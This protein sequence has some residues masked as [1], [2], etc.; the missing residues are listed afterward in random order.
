[1]LERLYIKDI[2][3][4][5]EVDL[6][7]REG[8]TVVTGETGAGKSMLMDAFGLAL[9]ERADVSLVR[10]GADEA[11]VEA[12]FDLSG[13]IY[14]SIK[15]IAEDLGIPL[16]EDF[17]VLRRFVSAS[18]KSKAFANGMRVTLGQLQ[19]LS[20]YLADIHGQRDNQFLL[21]PQHHAQ[22]LDNFAG[23]KEQRKCVAKCWRQWR[24]I[25]N[26]LQELMARHES[27]DRE[28]GLLTAYL[29][30]LEEVNYNTG[31]EISLVK[32]RAR[33]M[34]GEQTIEALQMLDLAFDDEWISQ[35]QRAERALAGVAD[36]AGENVEA[37]AKRVDSLV[38][39]ITDIISD[40]RGLAENTRPDPEM[41]QQVDNRLS[42]L[43][44]IARKHSVDVSEIIVVQQ[45]LSKQLEDL[46]LLQDGM[47]DLV[48]HEKE[49]RIEYEK[50]AYKLSELRKK[51]S[52][53]M[54]K[55]V[56]NALA[57]LKMESTSFYVDFQQLEENQWN[58]G[59]CD[60][61][62]FMLAVNAGV[63]LQPLEKV[64]SGGEVSR[65]MLAL[66]QVFFAA[67]PSRTLVFDEIDTG[68]GGAVADAVGDALGELGKR[69]Q[70]LVVTHQ[71]QVA[72]KGGQHL[73]IEKLTDGKITR[74][75]AAN[76]DVIKRK[77]ELARMLSGK[78]VT[79]AAREAAESLLKGAA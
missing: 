40:V 62:Q 43:R 49:A 79:S 2:V 36:K 52:D 45:E 1:M 57:K 38:V 78:Q 12:T 44:D 7:L 75:V 39:E 61:I 6:S 58:V 26:R 17:L 22:M 68:V 37:F 5:Q 55:A 20:E 53:G 35:I 16:E 11:R 54:V 64:A 15:N 63:E 4:I 71:P 10:K 74:T 8:L 9:G 14:D 51:N 56:Q 42:N 30:E 77:E 50:Q 76:L 72:A 28:E 29:Q 31:E 73:R 60:K 25:I 3:L 19:Q 47:E 41:L 48:E 34:S 18:G 33:L 70:V 66:K 27:R 69:H 46:S 67:M 21:K 13:E 59:G 23:L 65:L 32:E 24:S